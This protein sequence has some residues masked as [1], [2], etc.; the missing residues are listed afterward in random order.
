MATYVL[1]RK[2]FA[3]VDAAN[4]A[5]PVHVP[6]S[7][8]TKQGLIQKGKKAIVEQA[9]KAKNF[10]NRQGKL[11][12]AGI[13]A[14][15]VAIPVTAVAS[16]VALKKRAARKAEAEQVEY[17]EKPIAKKRKVFLADSS[18]RGYG[19]SWL[20]GGPASLVG[21]YAGSKEA[22]KASEE[23]ESVEQIKSRASKKAAKVGGAVG[24]GLGVIG[25]A[26]NAKSLG[27]KNAKA[28]PVALSAGVGTAA[29]SAAGSYLG[30]KKNTRSRVEKGLSK[31]QD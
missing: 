25:G 1:R 5:L 11:G 2:V 28:I 24:A 7:S 31:S 26:V 20:I 23:G 30:A 6:A 3:T 17:S 15:T 12:K 16:G 13:I 9:T 4:S 29:L 19:R 18:A 8:K 27:L 22:T 21:T 10:Y 14:G